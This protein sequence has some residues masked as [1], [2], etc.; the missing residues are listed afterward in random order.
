MSENNPVKVMTDTIMSIP[1][2]QEALK[3]VMSD[4]VN[5]IIFIVIFLFLILNYIVKN[6]FLL[7]Y[8]ERREDKKQ[9]KIDRYLSNNSDIDEMCAEIV[10]EQ[11]DAIIFKSVTGIYAEKVFRCALIDLRK[12]MPYDVTWRM[13]R[14]SLSRFSL[15]DD[16]KIIV[17]PITKIE[18]VTMY[19]NYIMGLLLLAIAVIYMIYYI[20]NFTLTFSD[21][22][23]FIAIAFLS[24]FSSVLVLSQNLPYF[25]SKRINSEL[26]KNATQLDKC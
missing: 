6:N 10:R 16:K 17:K 4:P 15:N 18:T 12:K 21:L 8:W 25:F 23:T 14:K 24:G 26:N 1:S 20:L 13:I 5:F 3:P 2:L 11:R 22:L 19:Y 7:T 9:E